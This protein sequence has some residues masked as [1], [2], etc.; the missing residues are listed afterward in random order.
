MLNLIPESFAH[1]GLVVRGIAESHPA[2]VLNNALEALGVNFDTGPEDGPVDKELLKRMA[3]DVRVETDYWDFWK[4]LICDL[5]AN[6]K[7]VQWALA[8]VDKAETI[9][10]KERRIVN[11][12]KPKKLYIEG[13]TKYPSSVIGFVAQHAGANVVYLD[14]GFAP[15]E[16]WQESRFSLDLSYVQKG[17]EAHWA[18]QVLRNKPRGTS[19]L[20]AGKNHLVRP[21]YKDVLKE[22]S[23]IHIGNFPNMLKEKGIAFTMYADLSN[24]P[25][26]AVRNM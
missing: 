22:R 13:C 6:P 10:L 18:N 11:E 12:I 20:I 21:Y 3:A 16:E 15:Y 25:A 17:R 2:S 14:E 4:G 5:G 8:R 23:R 9:S 7:S 24:G 1:K 26:Q 19:L